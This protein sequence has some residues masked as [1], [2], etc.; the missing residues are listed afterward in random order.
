MTHQETKLMSWRVGVTAFAHAVLPESKE[1][2]RKAKGWV[3]SCENT[4][5]GTESRSSWGPCS[6]RSH[7]LCVPK[8]VCAVTAWETRGH[9][10][11]NG[12]PGAGW[13][14]VKRALHLWSLLSKSH[15]PRLT[16]RK[17]WATPDCRTFWKLPRQFFSSCPGSRGTGTGGHTV[18]DGRRQPQN[19]H[20]LRIRSSEKPTYSLCQGQLIAVHAPWRYEA[21]RMGDLGEASMGQLLVICSFSV[22]LKPTQNRVCLEKNGT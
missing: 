1:V 19:T 12:A 8:V 15:N 5:E 9:L 20:G 4:W 14:G 18:T 22:N 13:D 3:G 10:E 2:A 16:T 7:C 11:D 6:Q 21:L 17:Q